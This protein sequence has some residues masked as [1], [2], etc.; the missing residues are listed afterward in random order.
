V[1]GSLV[2]YV[3]GVETFVVA[4]RGFKL[5]EYSL[6]SSLEL[7]VFSQCCI[8]IHK[9]FSLGGCSSNQQRFQNALGTGRGSTQVH[10]RGLPPESIDLC[11]SDINLLR[12]VVDQLI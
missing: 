11:S 1:G 8:E 4:L 5:S 12:I 6:F 10:A 3:N 7:C 9:W 2:K